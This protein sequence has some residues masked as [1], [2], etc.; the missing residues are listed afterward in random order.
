MCV[1]LESYRLNSNDMIS[2][3]LRYNDIFMYGNWAV[4]Q[5]MGLTT[6]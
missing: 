6:A 4:Y 2:G 5:V 1:N 3:T